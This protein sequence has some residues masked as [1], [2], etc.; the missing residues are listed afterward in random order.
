MLED[1]LLRELYDRYYKF[2]YRLAS[3]RLYAHTGSAED[4]QDIV[5]DVFLLAA[6]KE[7]YHHPNP[8][9]WL[10]VTTDYLCKNHSK[11][12]ARRKQKQCVIEDSHPDPHSINLPAD[13][14]E[15]V[16]LEL[17]L[18]SLLSSEDYQ[19]ITDHYMH[20]HSL[21]EIAEEMG[22]S[23]VA[24]R[25]RI[26]RIR[27]QLK[28]YLLDLLG[29][30]KP[31]EAE[32]EA[33]WKG[34]Q[35]KRNMPKRSGCKPVLRRIAAAAAVLAIMFVVTFETAQAFRWSFLLKLLAPV[36]E[37]FGIYSAGTFESEVPEDDAALVIDD[38][39]YEQLTY[40]A[41]DQ[42]PA[43]V[44][45]YK[46]V[47]DW[48]PERFA[49][50]LGTLYEDPDMAY[51]T[52]FYQNNDE[53]FSVNSYIYHNDD[54]VFSYEYERTLSEPLNED[55]DGFSV[56]FYHNN[57]DG[58]VLAASWIDGDA[59]YHVEGML[60]YDELRQIISSMME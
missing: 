28:K 51:C 44:S 7:I 3:N 6:R 39:G 9:G 10:A 59:H 52:L 41:L 55:I 17:T 8:G 43:E 33:C 27:C 14:T 20:K 15:A 36:A 11:K 18:Q 5:Q 25:V 21:S 26:H 29:G 45:G 57:E 12:L 32:K 4:V 48:T 19:I 1:R 31:A 37:T 58:E 13:A 54:T 22:L 35:A 40:A 47:P 42:M 53:A 38:T 34:I 16:D 23:H 60:T 50:N 49:F 24:V 56:S 2:V 46:V 30:E